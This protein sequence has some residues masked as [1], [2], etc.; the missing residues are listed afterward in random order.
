MG[1]KPELAV[2]RRFRSLNVLRLLEMQSNLMQQA[3]DYKYICSMDAEANCSTTR[4]YS[5]NWERLYE[6]SG[7]GGSLQ[8]DAWKKLSQG[9]ESYSN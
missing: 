9:L 6:S 1:C 4:S 5:Q 3:Q 7:D 8:K 2:F